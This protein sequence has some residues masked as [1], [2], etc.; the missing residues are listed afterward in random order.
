MLGILDF[1]FIMASFPL[2]VP[3]IRITIRAFFSVFWCIKREHCHIREPNLTP[4]PLNN[5]CD[6]YIRMNLHC[7]C[8][9]VQDLTTGCVTGNTI[10]KKAS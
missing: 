1:Y 9:W 7:K 3:V 4:C 2:A 5:F 8:G 6:T 10:L